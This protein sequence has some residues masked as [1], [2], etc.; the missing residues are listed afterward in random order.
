MNVTTLTPLQEDF[1]D[2]FVGEMTKEVILTDIVCTAETG[3]MH[4]V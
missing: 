4:P 1:V 2:S 3:K